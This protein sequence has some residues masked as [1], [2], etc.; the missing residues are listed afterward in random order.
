MKKIK[1]VIVM[2]SVMISFFIL[3][4]NFIGNKVYSCENRYLRYLA[5]KAES[6]KKVYV[7]DDPVYYVY[8][9]NG[10]TGVIVS[11]F[12]YGY[13]GRIYILALVGTTGAKK[14]RLQKFIVVKHRETRSYFYRVNRPFFRNAFLSKTLKQLPYGEKDF[15]DKLGIDVVSG[16]TK[17]SIGILN[18]VKNVLNKARKLK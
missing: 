2:S 1:Y 11:G 4:I 12:G 18:A 9:N 7:N 10:K 15:K 17:S 5:P 14:N 16:A 3:Y 8:K 6:I 13:G